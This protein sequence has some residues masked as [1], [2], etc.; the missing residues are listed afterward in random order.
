MRECLAHCTD[1]KL[2]CLEHSYE[3]VEEL[4]ARAPHLQIPSTFGSHIM[5]TSKTDVMMSFP[6]K[7]CGFLRSGTVSCACLCLQV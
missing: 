2:L 3:L 6:A 4:R 5:S 1:G 7:G